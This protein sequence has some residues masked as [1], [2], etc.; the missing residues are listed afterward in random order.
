MATSYYVNTRAQANGDHE[1][2]KDGCRWMPAAENTRYLGT[3]TFCHDAV[4][5]AKRTYRRVNGCSY[6]SPACHTG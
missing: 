4:A 1:V 2:H 3:F 5:T 6:C